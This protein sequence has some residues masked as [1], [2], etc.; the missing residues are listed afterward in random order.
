MAVLLITHDLN[1]VRKFADR[2]A[3]MENGRLVE[4]GTVQEVF[5]APRHAYTRKLIDSRPRRDVVE[6]DVAAAPSGTPLLQARD[7][8][9]AYPVPIPGLR[10]WFRKGAFVAVHGAT[11]TITPGRTLGV[12]GESGSG[13]STLALAAL[14]LQPFGGELRVNGQAWG[15]DKASDKA[16]RRTLQVVFQDP[17]SSLSPRMTVEEIVGEGL[18]VHQPSMARPDRQ[19]QVLQALADVGLDERQFPNLLTRYPHEFSGGQRQRLA[20]ARAL[21]VAPQLLVLD[22]PTSALDVTI[23]QQ[24]L[25]LLQSLQRERQLSYLLITHDV[26]VIRAMAHDVLVMKDGA[27]VESGPLQ[28]VLEAPRHPYTRALVASVA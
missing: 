4:H 25:R 15:R 12:I 19:Q 2:V 22:E 27:I 10:G 9:V 1:L 21:I 26:D 5:A 3:V 23:Q 18:H 20:V 6:V 16:L 24:V 17:F 8:S 14:G 11:F 28:Q 13:K 7:L